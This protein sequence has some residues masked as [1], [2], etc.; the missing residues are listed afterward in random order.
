MPEHI[1]LDL[2]NAYL[3]E[4]L[5]GR[6]RWEVERH[7]ETCE[8]CKEEYEQLRRLA[9][10]IRTAP[11]P[12]F[13]PTERFTAAL[14][15]TLPTRSPSIPH[16]RLSSVV[17]FAP[18]GLLAIWLILRLVF[19]SSSLLGLAKGAGLIQDAVTPSMENE[20]NVWIVLLQPLIKHSGTQ[21]QLLLSLLRSVSAAYNRL[22]I[23]FLAQAG[24]AL[25]YWL[26]IAFSPFG[27]RFTARFPASV[28]YNHT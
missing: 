17:W 6:L 16:N 12:S 3:D 1:P 13:V 25:A 19:L 24:I 28:S 18:L 8:A 9:T 20:T 14:L 2:L 7:L 5:N 22:R 10:L 21:A 23:G 4:E 27:D 26:W 15:Q 11:A